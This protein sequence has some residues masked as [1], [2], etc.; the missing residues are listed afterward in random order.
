[1]KTL[2]GIDV[3]YSYTKVFHQGGKFQFK[4]TIKEDT[5]DVANNLEVSFENKKYTIGAYDG[6]Y[7]TE[8]NKIKSLNFKLCLFTAIAK[9]MIYNFEEINLVTGLP[10]KYYKEQKE[11]LIKE[12]KGKTISIFLGNTQKT[13]IIV[14]MLVFPQSTGIMITEPHLLKNET[15]IIDI[16]GF[17]ADISY[18]FNTQLR[19]LKTLELGI[20]ILADKLVQKIKAEYHTSYDIL[21]IDDILDTKEII[22]KNDKGQNRIINI[23]NIIES[24]LKKHADFIINR[25]NGLPEAANSKLIFIGGGTLRLSPYLDMEFSNIQD[26]VYLNAKAYFELG[27]VKLNG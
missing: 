25:I 27:K 4:S 2:I 7:D 12:F 13:F 20:N 21:K 14:D 10:A 15:C 19:S 26:T 24:E 3:G 16:G 5:L 9:A 1:M 23:T 18:F 22:V 11:E 6:L 8:V 17:T